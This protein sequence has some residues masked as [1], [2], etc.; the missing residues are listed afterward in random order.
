MENNPLISILQLSIK[1]TEKIWDFDINNCVVP[2]PNSNTDQIMLVDKFH[3]INEGIIDDKEINIWDEPE[4]CEDN[5]ITSQNIESQ[6]TIKSATLNKLI[7]K[8]TSQNS[9]RSRLIKVFL[10]TY[11]SFTTSGKLLSKLFQRYEVPKTIIS[12]FKS[13]EEFNK[14]KSIIQTRT[15]S[16]L[17]IWLERHFSDFNHALIEEIIIW[18][19]KQSQNNQKNIFL[20]T[21]ITN[22]IEKQ[23]K[24]EKNILQNVIN[25]QSMDTPEPKIPKNIFSKQLTLFDIDPEEIARQMSILDFKDFSKI[26]PVELLN[27]AWSKAKLKSRS[28]NVLK[29]IDRFNQISNSISYLILKKGKIKQR[30]KV[31]KMVINVA[32]H[33]YN[34]NN[35]N[36]LNS[37]MAA[38]ASSAIYRLKFTFKE[39]PNK[40]LETFKKLKQVVKGDNNFK[41]YR[42]LLNQIQPPCIPFMGVFL[43]DLTFIEDGN[44]DYFKR[45]LINVLKCNLIYGTIEQIQRYQIKA[46]NLHPVYQFLEL[47]QNLPT[48]DSEQLYSLSLEIEPK[49]AS[50]NEIK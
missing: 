49:N 4:D 48:L 1:N 9:V 35:F 30:V 28:K 39:L 42:Q 25:V 50:Q 10:M 32:E 8:I 18:I 21:Q 5:F 29:I 38:L 17:K 26:K 3:P 13:V 7:E 27:C 11:Q 41:N 33:L 44:P 23:K 22:A 2:I 14:Y 16:V 36:S 12:K 34:L 24:Q 31:L 43:S 37:V 15:I 46:Y 19:A 45:R 40:Q 6:I 20:L 47:L